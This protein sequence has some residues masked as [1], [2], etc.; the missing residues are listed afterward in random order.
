MKVDRRPPGYL[1]KFVIAATLAVAG[2]L[3]Y[4]PA[5][6]AGCPEDCEFH[7][8][9]IEISPE[10]ECLQTEAPSEAGCVCQFDLKLTNGCDNP[11]E[12]AD[13]DDLYS[14]R[15][16]DGGSF[17][18]CDELHPGDSGLVFGPV[19]EER[20]TEVFEFSHDGTDHILSMTSRAEFTRQAGCSVAGGGPTGHLPWLAVL[21]V[22]GVFAL[23]GRQQSV[24]TGAHR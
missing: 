10:L 1:A 13:P 12:P 18:E 15:T 2:I 9:E 22:F 5:A 11:I 7:D 24:R 3:A 21:L 8:V 19:S 14:C 16:E 23:R 17:H 4:A 20:A 6:V